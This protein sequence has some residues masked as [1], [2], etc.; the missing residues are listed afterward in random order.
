M[1]KPPGKAPH[2]PTC[3]PH[4]PSRDEI[5]MGSNSPGSRFCHQMARKRR[6]YQ[7]IMF[8]TETRKGSAGERETT[9]LRPRKTPQHI[10]TQ[11][12]L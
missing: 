2:P 3:E 11:I 10:P 5:H 7:Q 1:Q 12:Q 4:T 6:A 9:L 8:N